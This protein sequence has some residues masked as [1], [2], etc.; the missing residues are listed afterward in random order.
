M[1]TAQFKDVLTCFLDS[2]DQIDTDRSTI[3]FDLAGE[4][5]SATL[6]NR[7]GV[8]YVRENETATIAEDWIIDRVANLRVLADRIISAVPE[9]PTFITPQG[10]FLD[11]LVRAPKDETVHVDDAVQPV[12][13]FVSR[14]IAG[15]CSVLYLT[16][17]AGEGK[18][19]LIH[20]LARL[21]A[22]RYKAKETDWLLVPIGLGGRPFLRFDDVVVASLVN[23]LRFQRLYYDAFLHLV[24]MNVIVPALDGFEEVFVENASG[25]AISSLGS[26]IRQLNGEGSLLIAARKAYFEFRRL[27]TQAK[28]LDGLPDT[29]VAFGR[30]ALQRWSEREFIEYCNK[31][32]LLNAESIYDEVRGILGADHPLLTRPVLVRRLVEIAKARGTRFIEELRPQ[33]NNYF[34]WLIDQIL[35]REA[36]EKWIDKNGEPPRPL[37]T[38]NEHHELLGYIAEEMW[39][40][41]VG[42]LNADMIDS[43]AEIFCDSKGFSP[44]V[45]RQVR[46]RI[47]QHALIAS[48]SFGR[49]FTFDHDDFREFF[50]GEQLAMQLI[51]GS[52]HDIRRLLR[53]DNLPDLSIET[54]IHRV[55]SNAVDAAPLTELMVKV[56]GSDGISSFVR[57]NAGALIAPLLSCS[58]ER[59]IELVELV[60]PPDALKA[61]KISNVAFKD[62]YFRP[63]PMRGPLLKDCI[64]QDCE[65]E[66]LDLNAD[67]SFEGC[68]L[69]NTRIHSISVCRSG[70]LYDYYAPDEISTQI[71]RL[72]FKVES[73]RV[74]LEMVASDRTDEDLRIVEKA[75]QTF[76]R[77]TYVPEGTFRLRLSVNANRFLNEL[78]PQLVRAGVVDTVETASATKY[79][80][81]LALSKIGQAF[82][83][84]NGS[85]D[86]FLAAARSLGT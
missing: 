49:E 55:V 7:R 83:E 29:A 40:S 6:E 45:A 74:M 14:K 26:L 47:K 66:F 34:N 68:S 43:L 62:C 1:D 23:Q 75:L 86:R 12:A 71:E 78:L 24:R 9:Y 70:V 27:E 69:L 8:V 41:R 63:T 13:E 80:R 22:Q 54:A 38:L 81:R 85:F 65:F 5:V 28:L 79:R 20:R 32:L 16:S 18:T 44:V 42:L 53:V 35:T 31:N 2:T 36:T 51:A 50:L 30:L 64:F 72:G 21:Q 17:D 58:H 77:M 60:F 3:A 73:Q 4:F 39:T 33:A 52:E 48:S 11:D 61:R 84:A 56:G 57:E 15:T 67:D 37:L 25:D 19:T 46:E 59:K 76:H 82:S 10:E